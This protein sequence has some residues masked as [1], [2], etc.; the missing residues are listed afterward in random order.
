M[1]AS[2]S[3]SPTAAELQFSLYSF[4][5][6]LDSDISFRTFSGVISVLSSPQSVFSNY[7]AI[8]LAG[9][10]THCT[11]SV[12]T[13]VSPSVTVQFKSERTQSHIFYVPSLPA[14]TM[15]PR[16]HLRSRGQRSRSLPLQSSGTRCAVSNEQKVG[17][18]ANFSYPTCILGPRTTR[19]AGV[20]YVRHD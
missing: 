10:I 8:P 17:L 7:A 4:A 5:L 18:L 12:R 2:A 1:A 14:A 15:N 16:Y 6:M 19:Q 13:S 11:L 3:F 9:R 20:R